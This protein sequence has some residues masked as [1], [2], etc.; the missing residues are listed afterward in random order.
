M[1]VLASKISASGQN[2]FLTVIKGFGVHIRQ[3]VFMKYPENMQELIDIAKIAQT[4]PKPSTFNEAAF[5]DSVNKCLNFEFN[6]LLDKQA[7]EGSKKAVYKKGKACG[8]CGTFHEDNNCLAA[9]ELCNYCQRLG[10][11]QRKCRTTRRDKKHNGT[12]QNS[13]ARLNPDAKVKS[14]EPYCVNEASG[15]YDADN[16]GKLHCS[17]FLFQSANSICGFG[18]TLLNTSKNNKS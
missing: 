3:Y 5:T 18:A 8:K 6:K 14:Y 12:H 10:H 9:N 13:D 7:L 16:P 17:N 1:Q 15:N 11:F 2:V 4:I